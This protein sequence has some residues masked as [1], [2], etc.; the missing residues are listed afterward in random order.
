[1]VF[2]SG[3]GPLAG[4]IPPGITLSSLQ[5]SFYTLLSCLILLLIALFLMRLALRKESM[6]FWQRKLAILVAAMSL[7]A[8][9]SAVWAW[10]T[11][12]SFAQYN[13]P[14]N[15]SYFDWYE[16]YGQGV[17]DQLEGA[18]AGFSTWS[19]LSSI[20]TIALLCV[21]GEYL[22]TSLRGLRRLR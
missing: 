12:Q 16:R 3:P 15:A 6:R 11:Y 19:I 7:L 20:A 17:A 13:L 14:L 5:S 22:V 21:V 10:F 9:I 18:V 2:A 8:L 1:M 4:D